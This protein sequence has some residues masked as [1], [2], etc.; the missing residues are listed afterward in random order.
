MVGRI[1]DISGISRSGNLRRPIFLFFEGSIFTA[2]HPFCQLIQRIKTDLIVMNPESFSIICCVRIHHVA[3]NIM[4]TFRHLCDKAL[5]NRNLGIEIALR[6]AKQ[7][8]NNLMIDAV[9]Y[10]AHSTIR[11]AR[12]DRFLIS[13]EIVNKFQMRY[14]IWNFC[15]SQINL[16]GNF[17]ISNS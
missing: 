12:G 15:I 3:N 14:I 17:S 5:L 8:E 6:P 1:P 2:L 7:R 9:I 4:I 13:R 11:S 10:P 16:Q